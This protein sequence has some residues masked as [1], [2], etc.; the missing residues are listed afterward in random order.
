MA[1]HQLKNGV[2]SN[3]VPY[4]VDVDSSTSLGGDA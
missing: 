2:R 1:P 3:V 4:E